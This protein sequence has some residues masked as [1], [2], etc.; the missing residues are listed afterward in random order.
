MLLSILTDTFHPSPKIRTQ[1]YHYTANKSFEQSLDIYEPPNIDN[2]NK[3]PIVILV[4]GSAWVGHRS[5]IYAQT[6][7][8]NSSG[9]KAVARLGY[10]CV[11]IRHRG[12]FP[13]VYS[14]LTLLYVVAVVAALKC[15]MDGV[16]FLLFESSTM[17]FL[18]EWKVN[19]VTALF[20]ALS[21]GFFLMELGGLGA[22]SF[23][24][25]QNDVMDAIAWFDE[26]KDKLLHRHRS[27]SQT[28][29][30]K[31]VFGGYS[32]GGHVAAT[33][34]QQAHMWKDRNLPNPE[35]YCSMILYISPVLCTKPYHTDLERHLSSLALKKMYTSASSDHSSLSTSSSTPE[36]DVTTHSLNQSKQAPNWFTDHLLHTVFGYEI[37]SP[38]HTYTVSPNTPH[39]F[40]G[41]NRE[42]FGLNW[43][44]LFFASRDYNDLL[45]A[46]GVDS[47]YVGVESN[48]WSI[49]GS[50]DL[51]EV[52]EKELRHIKP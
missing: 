43:L 12:S 35:V 42:L 50:W 15:L 29:R 26:N 28:L 9:P 17:D 18:A 25:M 51:L 16:I 41:C 34:M 52:L 47:K 30:R 11:C 33:V 38:I 10:T 44:D 39:L 6:S 31:I 32:S 37:P 19:G 46:K 5:F 23:T 2:D 13:R 24:E 4:V 1:S 14:I 40:I 21:T 48:H 45:I 3:K 49:L 22:A 20:A 8:W 27:S 36:L 7:W